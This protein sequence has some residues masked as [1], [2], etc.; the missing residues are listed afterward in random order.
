MS[1]LKSMVVS[2]SGMTAERLRMDLIANNIANANTTRTAAGGPYRRQV[3]L[4]EARQGDFHALLG[5]ALGGGVRVA[6]IAEDGR[7]FVLKYDPEHPDAGPD[8]YVQLPNV[9][10]VTEMVDLITATRAYEAG[11]TALEAARSMAMRAL[12]LGR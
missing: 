11:A 8:G 7:P 1:L 10:I 3:A 6:R 5:Q 12:D 4:L 9:E 2:A